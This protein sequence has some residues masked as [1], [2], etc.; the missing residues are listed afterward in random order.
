MLVTYPF[1][2]E[3]QSTFVFGNFQQFHSTPLI[4]SKAT[5]FPD[6]VSYKLSVFGQALK[7]RGRKEEKNIHTY[8]NGLE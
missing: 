2:Y 3:F 5:D 4:G 7:V 1:L 8:I 6:H